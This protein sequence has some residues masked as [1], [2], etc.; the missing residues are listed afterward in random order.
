MDED[1]S[2]EIVETIYKSTV[3]KNTNMI[4]NYKLTEEISD[5]DQIVST[6]LEI[7]DNFP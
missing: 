3:D 1:I 5:S 7:D 6:F 4:Y 2:E